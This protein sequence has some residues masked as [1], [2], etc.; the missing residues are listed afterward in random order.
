MAAKVKA[1][2]EAPGARTLARLLAIQ[3]LF[4]LHL[5]PSASPE[6]VIADMAHIHLGADEGVPL[7]TQV[8][9]AFFEDLVAGAHKRREEMKAKLES[10]LT[11]QWGYGRLENILAVILEAATYELAARPDVPKAVVMDEYVEL[12]KAF[13][14][15]NEPGFVN[16]ILNELAKTLRP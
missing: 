16:G 1:K 4:R 2:T 15:G 5:D 10:V 6:G 3:A 13:Y 9:R 8:D 12:T 7:V 14:E 11:G